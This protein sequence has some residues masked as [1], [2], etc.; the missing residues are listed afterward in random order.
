MWICLF[1]FRLLIWILGANIWMQDIKVRNK[2]SELM[3]M[4]CEVRL[5]PAALW[6]CNLNGTMISVVAGVGKSQSWVRISEYRRGEEA[7]DAANDD[8]PQIAPRRGG[9]TTDHVR[10]IFNEGRRHT[11]SSLLPLL[12]CWYGLTV[13]FPIPVNEHG[14]R[15]MRSMNVTSDSF[16]LFISSFLFIFLPFLS[17][18][19]QSV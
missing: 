3:Q 16:L 7:G 2:G 15:A 17:S 9:T 11:G 18:T 5:R 4:G 13:F 19:S 6:L 10:G 8:V 14:W 1:F 12:R